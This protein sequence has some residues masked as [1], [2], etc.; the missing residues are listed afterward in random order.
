MK[1]T[2]LTLAFASLAALSAKA[3]DAEMAQAVVNYK[4]THLRDTTQKD[5]PYTEAMVLFLGQTSSVYRSYDK[6]LQD[7]LMRKQMEQQLAEQRGNSQINIKGSSTRPLTRSEIFQFAAKNKMVRKEPVI[8]TTYLIEEDMPKINWKI[9]ADTASFGSLHCQ[10]ATGRFKGRDYTAWFCPDVPFHAGPW[11]LNGLP[12]LI[13][14]AYDSKKEVEFKFESLEEVKPSEK[15]ATTEAAAPAPGMGQGGVRMFTIGGDD[16]NADPNLIALPKEGVRASP[17]EFANL[18]EARKKDPQGFAKS[19]MA[20]AGMQVAPSG[21]GGTT[22]FVSGSSAGGGG[23]SVRS[24]SFS[25]GPGAGGA[26]EINNPLELPE[27]K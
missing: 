7:A 24:V 17:K 8:M 2:L 23:G 25:A 3:Q 14:E 10:K 22:N 4:F 6:K 11:K 1:N 15:P 9:T 27:K 20:A 18:E 21:G 13:V 12:G 26:S 19:Q 5:K 16:P